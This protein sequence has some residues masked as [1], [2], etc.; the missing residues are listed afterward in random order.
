MCKTVNNLLY[1]SLAGFT[2]FAGILRK[3]FEE[4]NSTLLWLLVH[5][6]KLSDDQMVLCVFAPKHLISLSEL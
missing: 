2:S 3:Y 1:F 4:N 5:W 6:T